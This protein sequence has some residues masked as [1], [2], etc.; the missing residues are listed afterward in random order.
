MERI[1]V[2]LILF[3][4]TLPFSLAQGQYEFEMLYWFGPAGGY[5]GEKKVEIPVFY[6][7][8]REVGG[9]SFEMEIDSTKL[10]FADTAAI[11]GALIDSIYPNPD[12]WEV[13]VIGSHLSIGC[14]LSFMGVITLP[15]QSEEVPLLQVVLDVNPDL[16]PPDSALLDIKDEGYYPV[17]WF[18]GIDG[19][20]YIHKEGCKEPPGYS[21]P[22]QF[23]LSQNYPNPFNASTLIS[24]TLSAVGRPPSAVTLRIYNMLG[25]GVKTLVEEELKPGF[26]RVMWDGKNREG[27]DVGSGVYFCQLMVG[28]FSQTRKMLILR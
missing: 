11:K 19:I 6:E 1:K 3:L 12:L 28:R 25:Q 4:L 2:L 10:S 21:Q 20:F 15:T 23:E 17:Y 16:I 5:P 18:H 22:Y 24:Y 26:Y 13:D 14:V 27:R 7:A 9:F 8:N